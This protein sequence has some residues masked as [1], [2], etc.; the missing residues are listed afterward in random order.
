[1]SENKTVR[2]NKSDSAKVMQVIQV[3]TVTGQGTEENPYRCI[4]EYW[5]LDGKLLAVQE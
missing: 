3:Q 4:I 2:L 5:S 1:M